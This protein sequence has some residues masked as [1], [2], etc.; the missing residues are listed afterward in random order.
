VH[1]KISRYQGYHKKQDFSYETIL[2][3]FSPQS[4]DWKLDSA[5]SDAGMGKQKIA[6]EP[7]I[8]VPGRGL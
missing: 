3:Q 8:T 1:P 2:Y 7:E 6:A 5:Q 4:A